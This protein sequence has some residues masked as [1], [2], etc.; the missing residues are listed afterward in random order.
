MGERRS[1]SV[2]MRTAMHRCP[3][4]LERPHESGMDGGGYRE[5]PAQARERRVCDVRRDCA[6]SRHRA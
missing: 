1:M 2:M 5:C 4:H 6:R 3:F